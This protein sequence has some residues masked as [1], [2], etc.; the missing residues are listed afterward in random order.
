MPSNLERAR[1]NMIEQQVRTWE[2]LDSA[3]LQVLQDV[4]REDFVPTRYR[5]LAFADLRIPLG[6]GQIMMRPV[7][8]GRMLQSLRLEKPHR[9]LEIGTG[10]GFVTACLA[11][12]T[13]EV[14]SLEI[15]SALADA[16]GERLERMGVDNARVINADALVD[17][18]SEGTFDAVVVTGSVAE[19]P[20]RFADWVKS[21]GRLFVVRGHSP[22]MEA[23][24][25]THL[26]GGRWHPDSLF[27]TDLP[28]LIGAEDATVFEF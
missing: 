26:G 3:V 21:G 15:L 27:E 1:F 8:E 2:V 23:V 16:A 24:C 13:G 10:S 22:V 6:H 7:E 14:V 25:L 17:F 18:T 19:V 12:L 5:K 20:A 4:P 11:Q 9:V 28:R